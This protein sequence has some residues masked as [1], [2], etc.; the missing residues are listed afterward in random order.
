MTD[1]ILETCEKLSI[2]SCNFSL[3]KNLEYFILLKIVVSPA[4]FFN[5]Y[6]LIYKIIIVLL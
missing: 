4:K 5:L 2:F 1:K 6:K 3:C